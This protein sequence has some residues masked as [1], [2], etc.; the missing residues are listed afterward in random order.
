MTATKTVGIH[1]FLHQNR[2]SMYHFYTVLYIRPSLNG[3]KLLWK[4][5]HP[6]YIIIWRPYLFGSKI[7]PKSLRSHLK[8]VHQ[9]AIFVPSKGKKER[10]PLIVQ[11]IYHHHY[12]FSCSEVK[13]LNLLYYQTVWRIMKGR[14]KRFYNSTLI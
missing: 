2:A 9:L 6:K 11:V 1:I 8:M 13:N 10:K 14:N 12:Y 7:F 3:I 5:S 4:I